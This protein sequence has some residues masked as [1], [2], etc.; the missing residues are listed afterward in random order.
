MLRPLALAPVLAAALIV[1]GG[2]MS[3][4]T[5]E[6]PLIER[7]GP[8]PRTTQGVPHKQFRATLV[9]ELRDDLLRRV[10]ELPD[11]V[12]GPTEVSLPGATGYKLSRQIELTHGE[13]I[14]GGREFGHVH[15]DGSLHLSLSKQ[16]AADAIR[17]G[18]AVLHPWAKIRPNWD[19]FVLLYNPRSQEEA[20]VIFQL[21]VDSYNYITGRNIEAGG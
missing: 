15:P 8:S 12:V 5:A 6:S 1:G 7:E 3:P 19:G 14:V 9:P 11:V 10:A 18:W 2:A 17:A 13:I 21:V 20:D 4:A 16:R